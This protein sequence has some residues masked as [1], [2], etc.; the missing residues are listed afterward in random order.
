MVIF[1]YTNLNK[2][3]MTKNTRMNYI[4][5]VKKGIEVYAAMEALAKNEEITISFGNRGE[6]KIRCHEFTHADDTISRSY[7]IGDGQVF[8]RQMNIDSEKSSKS[9]LYCYSYDLFSNKTVAKLNFEHI[10]LV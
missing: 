6:F 8:G 1:N 4:D 9:Y 2:P 3:I 7:T 5:R 10:T